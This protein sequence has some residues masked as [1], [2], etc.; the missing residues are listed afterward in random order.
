MRALTIFACLA[1][2]ATAVD[3]Q[4]QTIHIMASDNLPGLN[5]LQT[6][7]AN[8]I[9]S[10][11]KKDGVGAHGCQV[12]IATAMVELLISIYAY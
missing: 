1:L 8:A 5:A 7:Y 6:E 12:A 4:K 3:S 2:G 9:I 11:A 10:M